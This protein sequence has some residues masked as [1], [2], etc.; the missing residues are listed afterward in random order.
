MSGTTQAT[1][2][3]FRPMLT[4]CRLPS[5]AMPQ[6][7]LALPRITTTSGLLQRTIAPDQQPRTDRAVG[8]RAGRGWRG[9]D[10]P[11]L[12]EQRE[13]VEVPHD[14]LDLAAAHLDEL[15]PGDDDRSS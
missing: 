14:L 4:V 7:N 13:T 6:V 3:N 11:E 8:L 2:A 10:E 5:F 9:Q 1:W 12:G 15:A